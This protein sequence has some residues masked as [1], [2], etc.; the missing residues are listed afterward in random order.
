MIKVKKESVMHQLNVKRDCKAKGEEMWQSMAF[1]ISSVLFKQ[2]MHSYTYTRTYV[3]LVLML[4]M[5]TLT[6]ALQV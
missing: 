3:R 6:N 2:K 4:K 1:F 5:N